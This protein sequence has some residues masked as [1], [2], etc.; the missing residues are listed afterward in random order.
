MNG[1]QTN[2]TE[3]KNLTKQIRTK[4]KNKIRNFCLISIFVLLVLFTILKIN[5]FFIA[6]IDTSHFFKKT[7]IMFDAIYNSDATKQANMQE[8][9]IRITISIDDTS[10]LAQYGVGAYE[11]GLYDTPEKRYG[12]FSAIDTIKTEFPVDTVLN[13]EISREKDSILDWAYGDHSK[14][15][16]LKGKSPDGLNMIS[17]SGKD[18]TGIYYINEKGECERFEVTRKYKNVSGKKSTEQYRIIISECKAIKPPDK[19]EELTVKQM[20]KKEFEDTST[21]FLLG[22]TMYTAAEVPTKI[23]GNV[24]DYNQLK[25]KTE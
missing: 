17:F 10:T 18:Y 12:Y 7:G 25:K 21:Y 19:W 16:F 3:I 6:P 22:S 4:K 24:E 1:V 23:D 8:G 14:S 15:L 9:A 5:R 2:L 13:D 11:M 20:S